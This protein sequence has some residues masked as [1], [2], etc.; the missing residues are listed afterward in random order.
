MSE[1][2]LFGSNVESIGDQFTKH[3][4]SLVNF[5]TIKNPSKEILTDIIIK[6]RF[7]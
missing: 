5:K 1:N 4:S 6:Y 3:I 7:K 2:R